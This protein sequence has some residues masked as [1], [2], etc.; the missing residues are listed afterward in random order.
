MGSGAAVFL[1][2]AFPLWR[3]FSEPGQ[4]AWNIFLVLILIGILVAAFL[5]Q[6]FFRSNIGEIGEARFDTR[7]PSERND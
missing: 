5:L 4:T 7:N 2:I 3:E 6:R 1:V